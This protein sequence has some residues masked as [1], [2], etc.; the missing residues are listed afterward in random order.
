MAHVLQSLTDFDERATVVSVGGVG[1]FYLVS[2]PERPSRDDKQKTAAAIRTVVQL[3]TIDVPVG[4][5]REDH[6][7][8]SAKG[9]KR[10][11][12]RFDALLNDLYIVCQPHRRASTDEHPVVGTFQDQ[13]PPC[14]DQN[15]EPGGIC[16]EGCEHLQAMAT[17]LNLRAH[18]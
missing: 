6:P 9:G 12:R 4:R 18:V 2:R 17:L 14:Q 13:S 15:L 8:H 1:G 7:P 5:R 3:P 11:G 16:P 10:T